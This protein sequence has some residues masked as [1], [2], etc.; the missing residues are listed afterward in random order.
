MLICGEASVRGEP[1]VHGESREFTKRTERSRRQPNVHGESRAFT[2][3][4]EH[5]RREPISHVERRVTFGGRGRRG[6]RLIDLG[7]TWAGR[8][9][10]RELTSKNR[11]PVGRPEGSGGSEEPS[12]RENVRS[13]VTLG[14]TRR[15]GNKATE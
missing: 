3:I 10:S 11:K 8:T 12:A 7:L 9:K 5:S 15:S 1:S 6:R 2:E 14:V 4:A 13:E